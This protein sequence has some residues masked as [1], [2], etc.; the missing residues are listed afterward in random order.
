MTL[1]YL[2]NELAGMFHRHFTVLIGIEDDQ[3]WRLFL[4]ELKGLAAGIDGFRGQASRAQG[5]VEHCCH[6]ARRVDYQY[7]PGGHVAPH[8]LP[9]QVSRPT[10]LSLIDTA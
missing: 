6:T 2:A 10:L 8:S 1:G 4:D 9:G 5:A 7:R 3:H